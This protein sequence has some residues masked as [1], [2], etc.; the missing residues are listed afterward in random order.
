MT[1]NI[2]FELGRAELADPK[3]SRNDMHAY[4]YTWDGM[5][6]LGRER[7]L[8]LYDEGL[9]GIFRLYENDAEGMVDSREEILEFDGLF[10][11]ED[12]AWIDE[13]WTDEHANEYWLKKAQDGEVI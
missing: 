13:N 2:S 3:I 6:P 8:E 5:I 10:G 1:N 4:G 9:R 11:I 12:T 7:A